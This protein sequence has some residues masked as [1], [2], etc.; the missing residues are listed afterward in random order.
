VVFTNLRIL[1]SFGHF[2]FGVGEKP[3]K[4]SPKT[5]KIPPPG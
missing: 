4:Y 1:P 2:V 5:A 3:A